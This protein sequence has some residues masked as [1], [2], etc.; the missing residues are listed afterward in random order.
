[1]CTNLALTTLGTGHYEA[2]VGQVTLAVLGAVDVGAT[3]LHLNAACLDGCIDGHG[4]SAFGF[5]G[6][7]VALDL[8]TFG[9]TAQKYKHTQRNI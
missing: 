9:I 1:M 4:V 6:S 5:L 2:G 3:A 7:T 8:S